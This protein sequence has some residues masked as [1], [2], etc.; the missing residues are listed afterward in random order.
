LYNVSL[1]RE[2]GANPTLSRN[3]NEEFYDDVATVLEWEGN[4][5]YIDSKPGDLPFSYSCNAHEDESDYGQ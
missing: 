1:K 4:H 5:R 2:I 3:C